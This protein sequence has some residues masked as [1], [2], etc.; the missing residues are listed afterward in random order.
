MSFSQDAKND[1]C[2]ISL[3]N[4]CCKVSMLYGMLMFSGTF[5]ENRI[6]LIT[7]TEGVASLV[8][9]LLHS[10]AGVESNLY[11]S[12]KKSGEERINSYKLT[13][14]VKSDV[15]RVT[16]LFS[17]NIHH[18]DK[19]VFGC[20]LC[21]NSFLRGAFLV[22]GSVSSPKSAY[23]LD[24]TTPSQDIAAELCD[25]INDNSGKLYLQAKCTE[26]QGRMAV[27]LKDSEQIQD[28]LTLIGAQSSALEMMNEKIFKD[29]RNNENRRSNCETANIYRTT[30]SSGEQ[31]RAINK[32]ISDGRFDELTEDLQMT[33]N[34]RLENPFSS[35][36]QIA[37][38]HTP[39][40]SKSGANHRLKKIVE[41][42]KK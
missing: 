9:G 36:E 21:E 40:I 33:A 34:I 14:A 10:L 1:L 29:V 20:P 25:M 6:K 38:L 41:I 16:G 39:P 11:V 18:I 2:T 26:R 22:G 17:G 31:V 13:V 42:S 5:T 8:S 4:R 24:I 15:Q 35:L 32:L 28:F 7:E 27:Y 37:M 12:E 23:H 30:G 3:K 19:S